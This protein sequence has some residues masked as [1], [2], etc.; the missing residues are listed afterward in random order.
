MTVAASSAALSNRPTVMNSHT[1]RG[2]RRESLRALLMSLGA[3]AALAAFAG[4]SP[5]AQLPPLSTHD[6]QLS[7]D[8]LLVPGDRQWV[9]SGVDVVAGRPLTIV[10]KGRV[11]IGKLRAKRRDD[12]ELDIGPE[13]TFF[14]SDS[15]SHEE[16]PLAAAGNGPAP[17][18]CLIGRIGHGPA[19]YIGPERSWIPEQTGRLW[20]GINDFDASANTGEFFAEVSHPEDVQPVAY[21]EEVPL[22]AKGGAPL[23]DC[24]VGKGSASFGLER[25]L[26]AVRNRLDVLR[27]RDFGE[28]FSGVLGS[29][30]VVDP[31][32]QSARLLGDP[33]SLGA[34]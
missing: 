12:A 1:A 34:D 21:R 19:F 25:H 31:E 9:D 6:E 2:P 26:F 10:G 23:P 32:P 30:E 14:Y 27:M 28:E 29:V 33:A 17:C 5:Q 16:F 15:L 11:R 3:L 4:C 7:P 20:L 8:A 18:F 22:S 13:G 24:S